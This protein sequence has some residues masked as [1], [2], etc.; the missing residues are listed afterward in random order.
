MNAETLA[1]VVTAWCTVL[2]LVGGA[3]TFTFRHWLKSYIQ[4]F[5]ISLKAAEDNLKQ[6]QRDI[7]QLK[8]RYLAIKAYAANLRDGMIAAGLKPDKPPTEFY[9]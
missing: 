7:E 5:N 9:D 6:A 8:A 1:T 4:K 2:T 3:V